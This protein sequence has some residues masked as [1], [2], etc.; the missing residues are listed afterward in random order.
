MQDGSRCELHLTIASLWL[1][2]LVLLGNL[3]LCVVTLG[4]WLVHLLRD[5]L[6]RGLKVLLLL[7]LLF[8]LLLL[9]QF[10]LDLL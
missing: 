1:H 9:L 4:L 2:L 3:L 5:W 6:L 7:L 8:L 10:I